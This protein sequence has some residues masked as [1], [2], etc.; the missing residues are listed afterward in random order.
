MAV[1]GVS[2]ERFQKIPLT[3]KLTEEQVQGLLPRTEETTLPK[4]KTLFQQGS[5]ATSVYFVEQGRVVEVE[6]DRTGRRIVHR[7]AGPGEYL[8]RYALVTGR[9]YRVSAITEEASTLLAIPLRHLYPLLLAHDDWRSWF[10]RTDI[11]ARLRAV[12]LFMGFDDWDV[13]SLADTVEIQQYETGAVIFEAGDEADSLYVVDQGQVLETGPSSLQPEEE[14]PQYFAAGSHFGHYSLMR[15]EKRRATAVARLPTRLFRVP[16]QTLQELLADRAKDL[17]KD[18]VRVDV[19]A[20]LREVPLFSGLSDEHL[21]LLAGYACLEYHRP[22][23]IVARQGEPATSLMILEQGEAIVR[24]QVGKG[25]PRPVGYFR[26]H[27][28]GVAA[29]ASPAESEGN[30][31]GAH[32][33]LAHEM[34]GATV[35]GTRPCVWIVL[36]RED[37]QRFLADAGLRPDDLKRTLQP[38][39][40][41]SAPPLLS[42]DDLPLPHKVRRHWIVPVWRVTPVA[43]LMIL[44]AAAVLADVASNLPGGLRNALMWSGIVI[45]VLVAFW[46]LYRYVDWRNDTYEVTTGAVIHT[47]KRLFFS[48]QRFEIPL[49]QIQNVNILVSVLGRLLGYGDVSIDTAAARGQINFTVIPDPAYVQDLIQ[50]AS[51]QAR[52]GLQIQ[53][54]E[55]IRQQLE[56]Q[57]Y[58]ERLKPSVPDSVLIQP[59]PE[60]GPPPPRRFTLFRTLSSWLPRFEIRENGRVIWRKH[61]FNLLQR[62]GIQFLLFLL[63]FYLVLSFALAYAT[64]GLGVRP[65]RLPPVTWV[66]FQGWLFFVLLVLGI[67]AVLWFIYQYVDWQNDI[68][69]LTDNEVIDVE[70]K[71]AVYPFFF[72]YTEVRRQASLA[73][74]QYADLRIPTPVAMVFN[75]GDVIVQTA[76][77]E[78]TLD[79]VFVGNPRRVH[80]EILRR[81]TA[82]RERQQQ[83]EFQ[84]RWGDMAQWFETYRDVLEQTG[85]RGS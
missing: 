72:F 60:S 78:G 82:Y 33:L 29:P 80:A 30:Y 47:E 31:F 11:A 73:N 17:P 42:E 57:L 69:I 13:Y 18:L 65:L 56:D 84:E 15:G 79:F 75:Y 43:I 20:K 66:G 62:T 49:Q 19:L 37:F 83:Q 71:L 54:R 27:R 16:G 45:L 67:A 14:W 85:P 21:R 61:W 4:G 44:I 26:A 35:E 1:A 39:G 36:G 64:A 22:G 59:Q 58:P 53:R 25:K 3:A 32:A 38:E 68:Y 24:F 5:P 63:S 40:Q 41:V 8:G 23:D 12:P 6:E 77:A 81:L 34:R 28:S 46:T 74:V 51:A 70:R 55:S 7:R 52:S 9:P 10:F 2:L 48:E 76:G 50:K